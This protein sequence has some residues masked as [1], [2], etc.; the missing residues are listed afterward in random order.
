MI[1]LICYG[2]ACMGG[3][4][5]DYMLYFPKEKFMRGFAFAAENI[6]EVNAVILG[7]YC[8]RLLI[9]VMIR[10]MRVCL[11]KSNF[12]SCASGSYLLITFCSFCF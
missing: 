12:I 2:A 6:L 5:A 4:V 9:P 10:Y 1:T 7:E 3:V 8:V 11:W